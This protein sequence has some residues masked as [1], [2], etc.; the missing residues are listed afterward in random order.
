MCAVSLNFHNTIAKLCYEKFCSLPKNGK[1]KE[2][3]W[4]IL[5]CIILEEINTFEVVALGTG[6]KCIGHDKMSQYGDV[7]N[8]SHA[9]VVCRRAFMRYIY[10]SILSQSS[11][12]FI[13]DTDT[14]TFKLKDS[15][16]FHFFSTHV[17]CGDAA[18][19]VK[20]NAEDFGDLIK[21]EDFVC[22]Q[23]VLKRKGDTLDDMGKKKI[24]LQEN[25]TNDIFRTGA[26]CL[27]S[28][29]KQDL[30][31]KGVD[32]HVTGVV[33]TKPGRGIPTLSV[34]CSD[35]L[36]KWCH[37]G[38][39]GALL[40]IVLSKPIYL[41]SVTI[42]GGTPYNEVAMQR[43][44]FNRLGDVSLE[45]PYCVNEIVFGQADLQFLHE[46]THEKNPCSS[47]IAWFQGDNIS[48]QVEV[49]IDGRRQGTTKK[50]LKT[51]GGLKICKRDFFKYFVN[52][53]KHFKIK[54]EN[55][56]PLDKLSYKE[57]KLNAK[58]YQ[59]AWTTLKKCFKNWTV[60]DESFL[61]FYLHI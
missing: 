59:K 6:S 25:N 29:I 30:H 10:E 47:S 3:E 61:D 2:N 37:L 21:D 23:N 50:Q 19:F 48:R 57:A 9:E 56:D 22:A 18:I 17:P 32:F 38:V 36:A 24:K 1:P 49:V 43:A 54:L 28:D 52:V 51:S 34:S 55:I 35:K 53:I 12:K 40:S 16:K 13:F 5:S 7:L 15:I 27:K 42:A 14:H 33:R 46:K 8:D 20:Q 39:Q 58:K 26:K 31:Q 11:D 41:S 4:T 60:K 45:S 44:L